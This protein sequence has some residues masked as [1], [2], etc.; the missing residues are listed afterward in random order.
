MIDRDVIG[1]KFGKWIIVKENGRNKKGCRLYECQCECGTLKN[2]TYPNL[3]LGITTQCK[4]CYMKIRNAVEDIS[5]KAF[6]AW[7]VI[8]RSKNEDR[9][10]WYYVAKCL[11][12][13]L[14]TVSKSV[15]KKDSLTINHRCKRQFHNMTNTSTYKIWKGMFQRCYNSKTESYKYYG[16]RGIAIDERWHT[17]SNFLADMGERPVGLSID[18]IDNNSNYSSGNCRWATPK[19][20]IDNRRNSSKS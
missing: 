2:Q 8:G 13:N 10:E 14:K 4:S 18:R 17:F 9:N 11:C 6:G 20:Q 19:E 16:A 3:N 1:M 7:T 15:L 12:G 5:G